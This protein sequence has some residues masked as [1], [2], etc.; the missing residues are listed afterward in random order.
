MTGADARQLAALIRSQFGLHGLLP[1]LVRLLGRGGEPVT[2]GRAAESGGWTVQQ[3]RGELARRPGVDWDTGLIESACPATGRGIRVEATPDRILS[4][5]PA[6]AV[7]SRIRPDAA[8]ADV[9]AEICALGSFFASLHAAAD[10][11]AHH[12]DG[13]LVPIRED[14]EVNRNAM[15]ELGWTVSGADR[16]LTEASAMSTP[17]WAPVDACTLPTEE[18]PLREAEFDAVF[19]TALRGVERPEPDRLRLTFDADARIED[20]VARESS[21]C[22]FFDFRLT[23]TT[24]GLVLDVRVPAARVTVLDGLARKAE[25]AWAAGTA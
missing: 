13:A 4:A 23:P 22:A 16:A 1:H 21:C 12:P 5:D 18:R 3:V 24:G 14:F 15:I 11:Q 19:A 25:A 9:R 17:A 20:L 10:W 2:V 7:V 8:V 6:T